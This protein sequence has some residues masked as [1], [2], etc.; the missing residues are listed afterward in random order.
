MQT[1]AGVDLTDMTADGFDGYLARFTFRDL[2][3]QTLQHFI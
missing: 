3:A 2:V 1:Q